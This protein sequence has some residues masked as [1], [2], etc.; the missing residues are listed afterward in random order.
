MLPIHLS[1]FQFLWYCLL[2]WNQKSF[3]SFENVPVFIIVS[4]TPPVC[5][6]VIDRPSFNIAVYWAAS[7]L[8]REIS[9]PQLKSK[10]WASDIKPGKAT[11]LDIRGVIGI[12]ASVTVFV[13]S[14]NISTKIETAM[15]FCDNQA[16]TNRDC[17]VSTLLS[18]EPHCLT[19]QSCL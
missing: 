9:W 16:M 11:R 5:I 12:F 6:L 15:L 13:N 2:V 1:T 19:E 14:T 3:H 17:P 18:R 7:A 10:Y 8:N 4:L